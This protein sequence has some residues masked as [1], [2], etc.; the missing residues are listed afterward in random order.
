[1]RKQ[2]R[3]VVR[4][5]DL[6]ALDVTREGGVDGE[7]TVL[8][9]EPDRLDHLTPAE[10]CNC[11]GIE[12]LPSG[13]KFSPFFCRPCHARVSTL[14]RAAERCVIPIGRHNIMNGSILRGGHVPTDVQIEH[15]A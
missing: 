15:L 11:C 14:N 1:M 2:P 12:L 10:L 5:F 13:S 8:D 7:W 9:G 4:G 3:V 6:T